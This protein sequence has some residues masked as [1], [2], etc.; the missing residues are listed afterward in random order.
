M[1]FYTNV[2]G[3]IAIRVRVV[4]RSS[5]SKVDGVVKNALRI[6]VHSPPLEGKANNELI[7]LLARRLRVSKSNFKIVKGERGREK[8][9]LVKGISEEE[10]LSLC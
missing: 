2:E 5:K 8:M 6:R 10:I 7:E 1:G 3:G 4:P 9:V